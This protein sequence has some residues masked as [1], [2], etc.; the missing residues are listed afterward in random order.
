MAKKDVFSSGVEAF[1]LGFIKGSETAVR[2]TAGKT[3][4]DI[5][6]DSPVGFFGGGRFR[7]NWFASGSQ[8]SVKVTNKTDKGGSGTV[9]AMQKVVFGLEDWSTFTYTNNLPYANVIEFGGYP[10]PVKL[11]TQTGKTPEG[12]PI[13]EKFSK[14]GFSKQAPHG[15]VR[16]NISK[17]RRL[18]E[19]EAKK[20]LPK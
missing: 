16:R 13:Y 4:K 15:V 10:D 12:K 7:G 11:G 17:A 8:P 1:S 2:V 5:T 18:L 6:F 14:G 20:A 9:A 19:V 3:F